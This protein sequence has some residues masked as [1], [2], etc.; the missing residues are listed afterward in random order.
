MEIFRKS[1]HYLSLSVISDYDGVRGTFAAY[2]LLISASASPVSYRQSDGLFQKI[3]RKQKI[4]SKL[5]L[6]TDI[7]V[8]AIRYKR[9]HDT[10]FGANAS[11]HPSW[12]GYNYNCLYPRDLAGH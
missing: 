2:I 10:G 9:S 1:C 11:T 5:R 6:P 12:V 8:D 4:S 3:M 7:K